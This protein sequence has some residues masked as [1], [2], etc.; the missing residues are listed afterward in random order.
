M[1]RDHR[2]SV[3]AFDPF[4]P[5]E[6][7]IAC[8]VFGIDRQE[9][10]VPRYD[11]KIA[12]GSPGP[13]RST[14]AGFTVQTPHGLELLRWADTIVVPGWYPYHETPPDR[15]LAALRTAH[16]RGARIA[17]FCSGAY[18]LAHAGLLDGR[19]A[20]THWMYADDFAARFPGVELE[21]DVLYVGDGIVFTS[22]GT[23]AGI[24]LCLEL[25]R[26]DH[27]AAVAN[28]IARRMVVPPHREGG[29]AQFIEAPVRAVPEDDDLRRTLEWALRHLHQPLTVEQLAMR[30][31]MSPRTFA[32]RFRA[33]TGTTPLQWLV[34]QRVWH[35]QELLETTEL[36]I[37][38]VARRAGFGTP[39]GLRQHFGRL[40]GT[41]PNA[42][43]ATFRQAS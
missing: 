35:A 14:V 5:F 23:A 43:R 42:Y 19:R 11:V 26:H 39:A 41:S 17:S 38:V 22:A 12:A 9:M 18:V 31:N 7:S 3:L 29:Q 30:A 27:G 16:R 36:P 10:G 4:P 1:R 34:Q 13:L 8:E 32:R 33:T 40:V 25:V 37:E 24:D 20:T 21:P 28:V 15:V 6:L 2:V